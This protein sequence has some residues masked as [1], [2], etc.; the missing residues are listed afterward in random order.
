MDIY[1][2]LEKAILDK[3]VLP[4]WRGPVIVTTGY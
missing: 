4:D 1:G 2:L 3:V